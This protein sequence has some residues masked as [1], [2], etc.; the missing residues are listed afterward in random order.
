MKCIFCRETSDDSKS[1][2]HIISES[3]GNKEHILWEGLVC[4]SCNNYFTSKTEK[5][6]LEQPYFINL[7]HRNVIRSKKNHLTLFQYQNSFPEMGKR[8]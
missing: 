2:E 7:R 3:L 4:D 8:E 6:L 5:R 1:V